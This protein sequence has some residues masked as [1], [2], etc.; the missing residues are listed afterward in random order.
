MRFVW[1]QHVYWTRMVLISIAER[2]KDEADTTAR[3]LQNPVDMAD[4]FSRYYPV[5][6][7]NEIERLFTEH[8]QIGAELITALRDNEREKAATLD[9]NWYINADKIASLFSRINPN[10]V[11]T[12]LQEMLHTHLD[13]TKIEV[14]ERLVGHYAEDIAAFGDVEREGVQMADMFTLGIIKQFK[15]RFS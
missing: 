9:R 6:V 3:L 2:L 15:Y 14:T 5:E 4:I 10:W 13:L 12:D 7:D 11:Y 8:L 1:L